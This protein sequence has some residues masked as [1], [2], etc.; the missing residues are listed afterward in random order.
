MKGN[1]D[2][3]FR[4]LADCNGELDNASARFDEHLF[5]VFDTEIVGIL[6]VHLD[7]GTLRCGVQ[8]P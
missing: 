8:L 5:S 7:L 6:G 1:K 3:A 4:D 2:L